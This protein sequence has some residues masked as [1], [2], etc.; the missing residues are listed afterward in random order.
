MKKSMLFL[1]VVALAVMSCHKKPMNTQTT[2]MN[3]TTSFDNTRWVIVNL[4]GLETLPQ[5]QKDVFIQFKKSDSSYHGNAGCNNF[6]GKYTL[7]GTKLS[8]GPA[9][10]TRMMCAPENMKVEDQL[11][12]AI[13]SVDQYLITGDHLQLKKGDLVVAEF[14]A[15]YL[16]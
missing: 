5:L 10:M 15:V 12:K 9:A 13:Q 2:A 11:S 1:T 8:L 16:K 4:T 7:D 6:S 14:H 3:T